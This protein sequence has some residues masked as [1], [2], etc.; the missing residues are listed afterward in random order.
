MIGDP[1]LRAEAEKTQV[2][3]PMGRWE[4]EAE[5]GFDVDDEE[6][7]FDFVDDDGSDDLELFGVKP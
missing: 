3:L 6:L 2:I 4:A 7:G 5:A 1:S